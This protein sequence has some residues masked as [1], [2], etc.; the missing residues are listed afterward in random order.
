MVEMTAKYEAG[1]TVY[2]LAAEFGCHRATVAERLKKAGIVMRGQSPTPE[3]IDSMV[4]LYA[5]GLSFQEVGKQLVFCA[6]TI[7]VHL[8]KPQV[9]SLDV[10]GRER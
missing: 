4:R 10:R 5:T 7:R 8:Q 6:N 1:A 9:Q 3:A 2:E